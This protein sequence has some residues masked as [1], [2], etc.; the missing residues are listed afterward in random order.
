GGGGGG[1]GRGGG[2]FAQIDEQTLTEVAKMTGGEYFKAENADA[3]SKVLLDLPGA[4]VLQRKKVEITF[5]FAF[6]GA[7]LVLIGVALAQWWNRTLAVPTAGQPSQV[8]R[9]GG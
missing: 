9:V 5:W 3:L 1:F 6:A 4:I 7:L 8:V 2:R